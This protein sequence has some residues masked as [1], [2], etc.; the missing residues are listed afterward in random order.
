[1]LISVYRARSERRSKREELKN[2]VQAETALTSDS[3][4]SESGFIDEDPDL[5]SR[6]NEI[7]V[8]TDIT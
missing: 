1:M 4:N 2:V 7:P 6:L 5:G 8:Q 3:D